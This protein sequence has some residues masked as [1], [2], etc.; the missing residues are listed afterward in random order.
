MSLLSPSGKEA[1]LYGISP[2][3]NWEWPDSNDGC[4]G[5]RCFR[6]TIAAR[7]AVCKTSFPAAQ[8]DHS[9][10]LYSVPNTLLQI[11]AARKTTTP[12]KILPQAASV[13]AAAHR[14]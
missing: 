3:D 2:S 5:T 12:L 14:P 1:P 4:D 8:P 13:I 6:K 10:N 11:D 7:W 9:P